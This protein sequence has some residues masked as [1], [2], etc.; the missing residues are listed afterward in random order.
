MIDDFEEQGTVAEGWVWLG[1]NLQCRFDTAP[2]P[3]LYLHERHFGIKTR[4]K[5]KRKAAGK[6]ESFDQPYGI[7]TPPW[8]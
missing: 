7:D 2:Y 5:K 1:R 6:K 8:V 4:K 3:Y